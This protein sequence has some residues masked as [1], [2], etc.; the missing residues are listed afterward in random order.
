MNAISHHV[1]TPD[2]LAHQGVCGI[3]NSTAEELARL[4]IGRSAHGAAEG[5]DRAR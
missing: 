2:E 3:D 4:A 5:H 1:R